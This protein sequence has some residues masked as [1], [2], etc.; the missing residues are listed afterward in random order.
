MELVLTI[1]Y[2]LVTWRFIV[3]IGIATVFAMALNHVFVEFGGMSALALILVG[4]GFGLIWQGRW[5]SGIPV[6]AS[7]PSPSISKP[8]AF[9]GFAFIGSIWGGIAAE[10]FRSAFGGALTLVAAVVLVGAWYSVG[11]KRHVPLDYLAFVTFSLLIGLGGI[12]ALS[13]LRG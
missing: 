5:L 2:A 11:L 7:V 10:L 6:F 8:V 13:L 12:Y 9:L 1:L 4:V 3:S